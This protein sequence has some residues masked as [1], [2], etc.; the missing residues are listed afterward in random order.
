LRINSPA[1]FSIIVEAVSSDFVQPTL[2]VADEKTVSDLNNFAW[3]VRFVYD[4]RLQDKRW[5]SFLRGW[6]AFAVEVD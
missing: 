5:S 1:W 6:S 2:F 3:L 4:M